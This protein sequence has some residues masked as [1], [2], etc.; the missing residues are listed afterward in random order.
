MTVYV[1]DFRMR[2]RV[3]RL[4]ARWSHLMADSRDE[5][6][7]FADRLGLRRAW[8]QDKRSGVHFDVTDSMR[9]KA[10]RLGAVQVEVGTPESLRVTRAAREQHIHGPWCRKD[11]L[12]QL[13][14]EK[15]Q[16]SLDIQSK[17]EGT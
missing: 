7:S 12:C 16:P 13:Q 4:D 3:G 8:L 11:L 5:L 15:Q 1:D 2:A 17:A 9:T 14:Q 6:L 10:I